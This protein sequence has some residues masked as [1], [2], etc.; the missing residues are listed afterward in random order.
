MERYCG[1]CKHHPKPKGSKVVCEAFP[2]G[3]PFQ[4]LSGQNDHEKRLGN[5]P[6]IWELD[7]RFKNE[8]EE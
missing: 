6:Y 7:D 3:I 5:E 1:T 8:S 2:E 4:I